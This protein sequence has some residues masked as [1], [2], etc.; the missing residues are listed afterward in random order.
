MTCSVVRAELLHGAQK[1]GNRDRRV[2]IV[3]QTLAPFVSL[4]FDGADAEAYARI[5]HELELA[6]SVI[7]PYDLQIAALC[8]R[9]D[10]TLVTSNVSEF[11]RVP[12]LS[13]EDWISDAV[14]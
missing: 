8:V 5:R 2:T 11:S 7:G 10:P 12:G 4:S 14:R 9:H 1:Y 3:K 6:G 13:M